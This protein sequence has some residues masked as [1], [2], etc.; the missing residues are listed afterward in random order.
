MDEVM[1]WLRIVAFLLAVLVVQIGWIGV[2]LLIRP[3]WAQRG[4]VEVWVVGG[5]LDTFTRIRGQAI[6]V[7][8]VR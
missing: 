5:E 6:D 2:Q 8:V 1:H 3:A 4:P 7:R